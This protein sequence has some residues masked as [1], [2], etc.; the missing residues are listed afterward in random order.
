[1]AKQYC[2]QS[3]YQI[4]I[5]F[6]Y[7]YSF[8]YQLPIDINNCIATVKCAYNNWL[9]NDIAVGDFIREMHF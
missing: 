9:Y 7:R 5:M 6:M 8:S 3:L 2:V 1:M 4:V